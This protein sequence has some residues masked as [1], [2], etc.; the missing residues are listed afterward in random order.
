MITV[1]ELAIVPVKSTALVRPHSVH[2]A[3]QGIV[4]DRRFFVVDKEGSPVTQR[5]EGKLALVQADYQPANTSGGERLTLRFGDGRLAAGALELGQRV[6]AKLFLRQV[7]GNFLNGPWDAALSDFCGRS[8]RL[9]RAGEPG[10]CVDIH[11]L[12]LLSQASVEELNRRGGSYG[13]FEVSRFR[14]NILLAGC[15]PHEEDEWL[16]QRLRIGGDL[17]VKVVMKDPRCAQVTINP[18]TGERDADTLKAIANYRP[19]ERYIYFGVYAT[20]EHPGTLRVGDWVT[21]L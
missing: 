17:I 3:E 12:S 20:I 10:Q 6:E 11:P 2:V 13:S 7:Q 5:E 4:E 21:V 18:A 14:P 16:E 15:A 8:L 1:Q 9:V 19:K